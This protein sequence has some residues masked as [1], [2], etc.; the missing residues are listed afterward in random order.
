MS[1]KFPQNGDGPEYFVFKTHEDKHLPFPQT[2]QSP[3]FSDAAKF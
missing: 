1:G 2:E 3:V